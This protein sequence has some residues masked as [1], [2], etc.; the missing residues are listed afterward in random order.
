MKKTSSFILI[1][2]CFGM[3]L[4]SSCKPKEVREKG[5]LYEVAKDNLWGY[6]DHNG[7]VVIDYKFDLTRPFQN[8]RALVMENNNYQV[9]DE[10][11]KVIIKG[12][13]DLQRINDRYFYGGEYG[14]GELIDLLGKIVED[15]LN[16]ARRYRMDSTLV[17]VEKR[18]DFENLYNLID[19]NGKQVLPFWANPG[20]SNIFSEEVFTLA[21][22]KSYLLSFRNNGKERCAYVTDKMKVITD[23]TFDNGVEMKRGYGYLLKKTKSIRE[24]DYYIFDSLGNNLC[25]IRANKIIELVP[26]Y[27][28]MIVEIKNKQYLCNLVTGEK[29]TGPYYQIGEGTRA[30]GW[31]WS[32][33]GY[34]V[35]SVSNKTPDY[36][37]FSEGFI[38]FYKAKEQCGY[39]DSTGKVSIPA[40]FKEVAPFSE[41]LAAV[42]SGNS[43]YGYINKKGELIIPYKYSVALGFDKGKAEVDLADGSTIKIDKTGRP[44]NK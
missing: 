41:G 6:E 15:S 13:R 5:K 44:I 4:F 36:R 26:A 42:R 19:N 21:K 17:V 34:S 31:D 28:L 11:G 40:A 29:I 32:F 39:M 7:N 35:V 20:Q 1:L 33:G 14:K 8:N 37:G 38:T 16:S 25:K 2:L 10:T 12:Y 30:Q 3:L 22:S 43:K 23:T 24:N 18:G 27:K 9:I